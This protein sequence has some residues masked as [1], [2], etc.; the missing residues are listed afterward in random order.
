MGDGFK[1]PERHAAV[2]P[3]ASAADITRLYQVRLAGPS[4]RLQE[5]EIACPDDGNAL[6]RCRHLL[7]DHNSAE[8]WHGDRL[9]CR[10]MRAGR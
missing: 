10:V 4:P 3:G 6:V 5:H 2:R 1:L 8:A 7:G 9:V